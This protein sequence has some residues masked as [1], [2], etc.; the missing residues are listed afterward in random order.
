MSGESY[1]VWVLLTLGPRGERGISYVTAR[2]ERKLWDTVW[3]VCFSGRG[4]CSARFRKNMERSGFRAVRA[5][6][7]LRKPRSKSE[8]KLIKAA[9]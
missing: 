8:L 1:P 5:D 3:S 6:V 9:V 2:S 4:P 7:V